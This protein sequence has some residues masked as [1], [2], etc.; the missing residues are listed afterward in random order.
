MK[1]YQDYDFE[2]QVSPDG[3]KA[4]QILISGKD[5]YLVKNHF[6]DKFSYLLDGMQID[7]PDYWDCVEEMRETKETLIFDLDP[8]S[9]EYQNLEMKFKNSNACQ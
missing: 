3:E 9:V 2:M 1:T 4:S 8:S 6:E 7:I 5:A